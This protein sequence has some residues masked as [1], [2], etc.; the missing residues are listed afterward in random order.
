EEAE[1]F[2]K[3]P[4]VQPEVESQ[5]AKTEQAEAR[6]EAPKAKTQA[7]GALGKPPAFPRRF[8]VAAKPAEPKPAPKL[9]Q[10]QDGPS[11]LNTPL[12]Q[13]KPVP[14][15]RQADVG[16]VGQADKKPVIGWPQE[17]PEAPKASVGARAFERLLYPP[18]LLGHA[19]QYVVDTSALP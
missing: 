13:I 1:A 14:Q 7:E 6:T 11:I 3:K 18:G 17:W 5:P 4:K 2:F 9:K 16:K 12:S 15:A 19:V 8:G 10:A